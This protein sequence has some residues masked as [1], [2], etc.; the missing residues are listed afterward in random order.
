MRKVRLNLEMLEVES[1]VT[2]TSGASRGTVNGH[3]QPPPPSHADCETMNCDP[4]TDFLDCDASVHYS[5]Y[6][7]CFLFDTC[8]QA[9]ACTNCDG[10]PTWLC[11]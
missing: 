7:S 5:C 1:F 9:S 6:Q 2:D 10:G 3:A 4:G 8:A 11:Y